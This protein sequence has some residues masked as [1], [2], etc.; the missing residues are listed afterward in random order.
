MSSLNE[1]VLS[2][3]PSTF[4]ALA[5]YVTCPSTLALGNILEE[6][7]G[8]IIVPLQERMKQLEDKAKMLTEASHFMAPNWGDI[9]L[10]NPWKQRDGVAEISNSKWDLLLYTGYHRTDRYWTLFEFGLGRTVP[11]G[12]LMRGTTCASLYRHSCSLPPN[13]PQTVLRPLLC[14]R[15]L[16]V[17]RIQH[18][19]NVMQIGPTWKDRLLSKGHVKN[20]E[21][22]AL[23]TLCHGNSSVKG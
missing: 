17:M 20:R 23:H 18:N 6:T 21:N 12:L 15:W 4:S 13:R 19:V 22:A 7:L 1:A 3:A 11:E 2:G 9:N 16:A 5:K 10:R 14:V 8:S